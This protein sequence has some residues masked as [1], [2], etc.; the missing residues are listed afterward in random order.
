MILDNQSTYIS[1]KLLNGYLKS[2]FKSK[3]NFR[4]HLN[5]VINKIILN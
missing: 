1:L 3:K 4:N 5:V 2:K